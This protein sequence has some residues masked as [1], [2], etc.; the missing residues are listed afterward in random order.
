MGMSPA[1]IYE[2]NLKVLRRR[3]SSIVSIFDQFS[4]V[5]VYHHNGEKWEKHGYEGSMFLYER[6]TYPPYGFYILNRMGMDDYVQR[7]YPEDDIGAH[8]SYLMLRSYPEFTKRRLAHLPQDH[9]KFSEEYAFNREQVTP[10]EKG[11]SGMQIIGLWMFT[12]DAREPMIDVM[13]RYIKQHIPYPEEFRYGPDRPPPPNPHL[14]NATATG[15]SPGRAASAASISASSAS[16]LSGSGDLAALLAKLSSSGDSTSRPSSRAAIAPATQSAALPRPQNTSKMSVNDLFAA[17]QGDTSVQTPQLNRSATDS[18]ILTIGG[19]TGASAPHVK[20]TG[21]ALLDSIFASAAPTTTTT[22][23]SSSSHTMIAGPSVTTSQLTT[24]IAVNGAKHA[25][26]SSTASVST[27]TASSRSTGK[28]R[29]SPEKILVH[30]PKLTAATT[31]TQTLLTTKPQGILTLTQEVVD[32]LLDGS[33]V[34]KGS[35]GGVEHAK[36]VNGTKG[37]AKSQVDD[38]AP[39]VED[40]EASEEEVEDDDDDVILE[41]DFADTRALSD[42]AVFDQTVRAKDKKKEKTKAKEVISAAKQDVARSEKKTLDTVNGMSPID[43]LFSRSQPA[44]A[45]EQSQPSTQASS[46]GH[47]NGFHKE[48]SAVKENVKESILDA[49]FASAAGGNESPENDSTIGT[50]HS[51]EDLVKTIERLVKHD[52]AFVDALWDAFEVR[53]EQQVQ[54]TN[55]QQKKRVRRRQGKNAFANGVGSNG[56]FA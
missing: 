40:E 36:V 43:L 16:S 52:S 44:I 5:C 51:R 28:L 20:S 32:G 34:G 27:S 2:H 45:L 39:S 19:P 50:I 29:G 21:N 46:N 4:H 33:G 48:T 3:D 18:A 13:L 56:V 37:G 6:D 53:S 10:E 49:I 15:A 22:S 12:T 38:I 1:S 41:L 14:R 23:T 17:L 31:T 24:M 35:F 11:R 47:V 8:G 26:T 7:I 54:G 42:M 30:S 55:G 9:D 25:R